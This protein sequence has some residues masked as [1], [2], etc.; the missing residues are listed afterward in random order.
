MT[1]SQ[2]PSRVLYRRPDVGLAGGVITGI[3][4]HTGLRRR[5]VTLLFLVLAASGGL[6]VA[7]Y[8]TYWIVLPTPE[9]AR[10]SRLPRPVEAVLLGVVVLGAIALLAS[11][12][13]GGSLFVPTLLACLGGA[14]IW[15]QAAG[16]DRER[17]LRASRSTFGAPT[18]DRMGRLRLLLGAALV[19]AGGVLVLHRANVNTLRDGLWA[20][21]V[22]VVGLALLGGPWWIRLTSQLGAE[23]AERIRGQER[24]D[25][26]AHLHD[27]VLQTLALIQRN[28]DSPREVTRLARGQ[29]RELRG[30]LY[31]TRAAGGQLDTELRTAAAEVEDAYAVKIDV[32]VVGDLALDDALAAACAAAREAMVNAARHSGATDISLYAEVEAD[33]VSVFVRDRG[34]GFEPG[35]VAE[36][37]QGVRGSIIGRVERNGGTVSIRSSPGGGTEVA[38]RMRR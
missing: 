28:A 31:G 10:R 20:I 19:V 5:T 23:R 18:A 27:S 4:L 38:I 12:I 36:D 17:W 29:E 15:R 2:P 26:A 35:A 8:A 3:A 32:V 30:L 14:T 25:L 22:T 11:R 13:A 16:P 7:L 33:A 21:G 6:G 9:G 24:A 37:R 1:P 34:V